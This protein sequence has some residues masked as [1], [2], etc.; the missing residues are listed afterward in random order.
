[1][2]KFKYYYKKLKAKF[3]EIEHLFQQMPYLKQPIFYFIK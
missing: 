3:V 1:M 2:T